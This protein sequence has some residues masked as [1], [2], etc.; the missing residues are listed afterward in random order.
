MKNPRLNLMI[1]VC[2]VMALWLL[3]IG[4]AQAADIT[5]DADCS[6][7]NAI[8]SANG[9]DLVEP[10]VN[11]EAGDA[12]DA[13]AKVDEATGAALPAGQD[14]IRL[15]V[16]GTDEGAILL[17]ATLSVSSEIVIEGKGYSVNG[18]GNQIF[19]VTAGSLTLKDLTMSG[20]FSLTNG[21]A[22]AVSNAK[23]TLKNSVVSGSGSRGHGGGIYALDSDVTLVDSVVS[24]NVTDANTEDF[25]PVLDEQDDTDQTE[26]D[27]EAQTE[28]TLE[29][30]DL[31]D[32]DGVSGGG[33]YFVS[34]SNR[35]LI[36]SS[37]IDSNVTPG[38]GGGLYIEGGSAVINN[39]TISG[40]SA[41]VDGGGVYSSSASSLTHL[42]IV[43]NTSPGGGGIVDAFLL[44]LYNSILSDNEGGDC[45]GSLNAN[46][47]NIIKDASCNHDGLT[48]DPEL[49]LLAG[50]PAYYLPQEGSP[51]IDAASPA[52][53]LATDQRG[54]KRALAACDIGASEYQA[55]AFS[56]Q[57]QSAQS[58]LTPGSGDTASSGQDQAGDDELGKADVT[59][60][61][62]ADVTTDE[63]ADATIDEEADVTTDEEADVT[64]D[65]E[66]D[67]TTGE[68]ADVATGEEAELEPTAMPSTCAALPGHITVAGLDNGSEVD[69]THLDYSTLGNQMLVNSGAVQ[70]IDISGTIAD[71]LKVC[72]LHDTGAIILLDA[73]NSPR[74]IVPLRTTTE[75]GWQCAGVDRPG[76]V[77]LMP[78]A[79][80]TS[81]AIPEPI[82]DLSDCT[83]TTN[84]ILNLR[85]LPTTASNRLAGVLNDVQ[86][87]ADQR[88]TFYY[89]VNYY[90]IVGWLSKDYL[91]YSGDC[92]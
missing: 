26:A 54:I 4:F 45:A 1:H 51:A 46:L 31:P 68:E 58:G 55:G 78:L 11:C 32:V 40:N 37:G 12:A 38:S 79:F 48:A 25:E 75:A 47:G 28:S 35:L 56:F 81:G 71:P 13:E 2:I 21:G 57:I 17:D 53:C 88:A 61:E 22:I 5:V 8:R 74:D 80:F 9:E 67:V 49:L 27:A 52:Y 70:A 65:E 86:L 64:T 92:V 10:R 91:T 77:V 33:I 85:A 63:G 3:P 73:A 62:E 42:T 44:Q 18:G 6:L 69:C 84:D 20:G 19:N 7:S 43:G 76:S 66:A 16:S 29:A 50:A 87:T 15:D 23:L 14:T 24:G 90:G 72:F 36:E 89:R 41:G 34:D 60:G 82:W 83:V 59:T 39:S 30:A